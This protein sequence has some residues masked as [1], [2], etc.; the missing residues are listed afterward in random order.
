MNRRFPPVLGLLGLL[1]A[2]HLALT[3]ALADD[4]APGDT[5]TSAETEVATVMSEPV[6]GSTPEAFKA[7]LERVKEEASAED[8]D[9]F[10]RSLG[11][12]RTYDLAVRSNPAMLAQRLNGRTPTEIIEA[13]RE[14][15]NF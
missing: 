4:D 7:S 9:L 8:Y 5:A 11:L 12:M 13:A 6:D 3:P 1:A 14:R 2:G 10:Q 15:Y